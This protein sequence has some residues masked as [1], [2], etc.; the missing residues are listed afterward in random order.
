MMYTFILKSGNI[1]ILS[2]YCDDV[3]GT[4]FLEENLNQ[5]MILVY[6]SDF[7]KKL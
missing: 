3:I 2:I 6:F 1:V 7:K 4:E 5:N